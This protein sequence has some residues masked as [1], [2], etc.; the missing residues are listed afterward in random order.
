MPA[1]HHVLQ[2]VFHVVAKIVEAELVVGAV[3]HVG[4]VGLPAL[5]RIEAMHDDADAQAQELIDAAHPLRVAAGQ[6]VVDGDDVHA[7]AGE[8]VQIDGEGGD[9][10]LAL[11]GLHLGDRAFVQHHAADEL[12]VEMALA[13]RA[14]G[15]FTNSC[16]GFR[17]EVVQSRVPSAIFWRNASVFAFSSVVAQRRDIRAPGR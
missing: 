13:E 1:L 16:E 14:L 2:L 8:R 17:Q 12:H 5:R 6:V 4:G 10:R 9:K 3:G 7:L 11:A 15:G